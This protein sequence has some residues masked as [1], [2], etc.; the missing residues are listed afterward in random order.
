MSN[1]VV[2]TSEVDSSVIEKLQLQIPPYLK[3]LATI[4]TVSQKKTR[5]YFRP[6]LY[7]MLTA[8]EIL[9]LLVS[10]INW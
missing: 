9:L 4:Y 10:V 6:K 3:S 1:S 2:N 8:F 5:H 7:Q